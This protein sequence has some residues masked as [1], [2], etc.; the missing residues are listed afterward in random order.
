MTPIKAAVLWAACAGTALAEGGMTVRLPD[1]AALP[2]AEAQ[3][4]MTALA[5]VNVIT[6][7]CPGYGLTDGE[8]TLVTATGDRLAAQL[9]LDASAY[10]RDY[11]APAFR[12]LDDPGACDRI[13][14]TARP[15]IAR[16]KR[17]G[18]GT[19]PLDRSQ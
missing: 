8:W 9:G 2:R 15:L 1:T 18:G 19:A 6:S 12:L 4:L 13:G 3:A 11:Y 16:L 5:Q 14:P 7:N 10:D 17:M